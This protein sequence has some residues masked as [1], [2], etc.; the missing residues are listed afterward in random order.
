MF[1]KL[2]STNLTLCYFQR[3]VPEYHVTSP[4][5]SNDA[6]DFVSYSLHPTREK[7]STGQPM[8]HSFYKLDAFG[9][10][11]HLKLKKNEH[12]MAPGMKVSRENSDGTVTTHPAPQN[13]FYLGNVVSD[14]QSTVAVRNDRGLVSRCLVI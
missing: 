1:V 6:G 9:S 11:L 8:D 7:R 13:T 10:I 4:Y 12:L 2:L 14:P 5:Q 3:K